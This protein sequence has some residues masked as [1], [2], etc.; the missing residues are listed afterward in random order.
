MKFYLTYTGPLRPSQLD[1]PCAP[2]TD[3]LADHKQQLRKHFHKQLKELWSQHPALKDLSYCK[4]CGI[5]A[6]PIS[7]FHNG[8]GNHDY[9]QIGD[10]YSTEERHKLEN[11]NF[12]PLVL[13]EFKLLASIDVVFLR[14]DAPGKAIQ[15]GDIDN[16]MKTLIDALRRPKTKVEIGSA[17]PA[18]CSDENPFYCLLEDDDLL[19]GFSLTTGTLLDEPIVSDEDD[20]KKVSLLITVEL[21]PYCPTYFNLSFV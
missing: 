6:T 16:R 2:T 19:S 21:K 4:T 14:R 5:A 20:T 13:P 12:L 17:C 15:A 8:I 11:F 3:R 7:Q 10:W 1:N 9:K 18:P